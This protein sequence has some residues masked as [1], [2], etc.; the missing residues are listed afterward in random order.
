MATI[1]VDAGS[2]K[3]EILNYDDLVVVD[4]WHDRCP[5]CKRLEPIF[6]EISDEYEGRVKFAKL[7][8]LESEEN[9][10]IAVKHGLMGTPT[11][12]FFCGGKTLS[13]H[14]GF[15]PRD[16]LKA[17]ID[18]MLDKYREC[19]ERTTDINYI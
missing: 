16:R 15:M 19:V 2:W 11:M 4:F 18:D 5:W 10:S 14:T 9:K 17:T 8:V 7:N 1:D 12:V 3:K 13:T 6:Q